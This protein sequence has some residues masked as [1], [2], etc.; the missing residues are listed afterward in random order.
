MHGVQEVVTVLIVDAALERTCAEFR[1]HAA[2]GEITAAER[3]LLIDGAIL[4][5]AAIEE[6]LQG[7]HAGLPPAWPGAGRH[8]AGVAAAGHAASPA[9]HAAARAA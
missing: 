8:P 9:R 4:L 5:A 3:D 2:D 6:L 7:A 1:S